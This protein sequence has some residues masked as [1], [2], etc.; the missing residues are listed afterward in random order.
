MIFRS[1]WEQMQYVCERNVWGFSGVKIMA[2]I[3][4]GQRSVL[5]NQCLGVGKET[6]A[7]PPGRGNEESRGTATNL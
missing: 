7:E 6:S 3:Q 1:E 2:M 5:T 4:G